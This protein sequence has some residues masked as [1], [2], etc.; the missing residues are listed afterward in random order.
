MTAKNVRMSLALGKRMSQTI[1]PQ[2]SRYFCSNT[3]M[4]SHSRRQNQSP[5]F[6]KS[7]GFYQNF[8]RNMF[9]QTQE[10]PNPQ[11]LKFL[12]GTK[13]LDP[14]CTIDFPSISAAA[15]SPLAK[16]LFRIEGVKA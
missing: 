6:L 12:P 13:V 9:I 14:G 11:S 7:H 1:F 8:R 16:L 2:N 15:S 4:I 10:T 3:M 5:N